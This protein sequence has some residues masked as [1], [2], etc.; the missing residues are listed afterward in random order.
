MTSQPPKEPEPGIE[1]E[2]ERPEPTAPEAASSDEKTKRDEAGR[3]GP[4]PAPPTWRRRA[5]E[6]NRSDDTDEDDEEDAVPVKLG[7]PAA[8]GWSAAAWLFAFLVLDVSRSLRPGLS[9]DF[10]NNEICVALGFTVATVLALRVHLNDL[11]VGDSLGVRPT[12]P[13]LLLLA[14]VIGAVLQIPATWMAMAIDRRWP[15]SPEELEML[16]KLYA[17]PNGAYRVA[18]A[19]TTVAL[20][21]FVEELLFRGVLFRGLRRVY[22]RGTVVLMTGALFALVHLDPRKFLPILLSGVVLSFLRDRAGSLSAS[23][24]AH[25]TFNGLTTFALLAGW[26]EIAEPTKPIPWPLGV[27]GSVG[28]GLLLA[29][30]S[31]LSRRSPLASL[32]REGDIS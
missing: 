10:V 8:L 15:Q 4:S 6:T 27:A 14:L 26:S 9:L 2:A 24:V 3:Q 29:L 21:P 32:A 30:F 17:I 12:G 5:D 7:L 1:T 20:G 18:F 19:A 16:A 22:A 28:L 23:L 25:M 13:F 11:E 31:W